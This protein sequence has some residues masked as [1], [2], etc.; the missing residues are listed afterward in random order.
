MGNTDY[1]SL[2]P[3]VNKEF[4]EQVLNGDAKKYSVSDY[5]IDAALAKGENFTSQMLRA[6]VNYACIETNENKSIKLVIKAAIVVHQQSN[7]IVQEMG[8]FKKEIQIYKTVIPEVEKL[9]KSI[10]DNTKLAPV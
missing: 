5:T 6:C 9:L 1:T 7:E 4:F 3:F 8:L 10:G 2:Y